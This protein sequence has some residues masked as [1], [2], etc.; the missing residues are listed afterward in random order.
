MGCA[1]R[2]V[3]TRSRASSRGEDL[4]KNNDPGVPLHTGFISTQEKEDPV[5]SLLTTTSSDAQYKERFAWK[6][7][8][9]RTRIGE[10]GDDARTCMDC[11]LRRTTT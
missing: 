9:S 2:E 7:Y 11:H 3:A 10:T 8:K 1:D 5:E 6:Q 4:R